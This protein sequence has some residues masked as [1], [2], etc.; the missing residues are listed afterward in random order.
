[1]LKHNVLAVVVRSTF[2]EDRNIVQKFFQ[3][4]VCMK[5]KCCIIIVLIF[6]K[7]LILTKINAS[8]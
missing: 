4:I 8:K 5:Y 6:K 3:M 2:E 1:M 7:E